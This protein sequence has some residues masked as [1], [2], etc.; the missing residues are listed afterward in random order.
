MNKNTLTGGLLII[1]GACCYG[2]L[3][4]YVKMAYISGFNTAEVTV[5]QF[6]LG[7]AGL[8]LLTLLYSVIKKR[9][10]QSTAIRT[11]IRLVI[12]GSSLGLTSIFYYMSVKYI[13]VSM[14]IVLLAQSVWMGVLLEGILQRKVPDLR[15]L[16]PA[17]LVMGGTIMA[18]DLLS[19]TVILN[20]KGFLFG[21]MGAICYTATMFS[22][23]HLEPDCP[24]LR[25][26]LYMILGGLIIILMV[27]HDYLNTTFSVKIFTGWGLV[28][29]LFGTILPPLLYTRGMPLIGVGTGA[30][31]ASIEIPI[32]VIMAKILLKEQVNF[33]QWIGITLIIGALT[34]MHM[35]A[36]NTDK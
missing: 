2:M 33:N 34:L 13:P 30:V 17:L 15:M 11:K 35:P 36:A 8:Y 20:W 12:A 10:S 31:L 16:L 19:Q 6:A 7:F 32:A 27:Y 9:P 21:M 4:T 5:S 29:S 28:I 1:L 14:A 25:R 23:K 24:P 3:G 18:T 26:S 22:A